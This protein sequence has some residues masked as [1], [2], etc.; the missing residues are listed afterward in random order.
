MD[1]PTAQTLATVRER[2][3]VRWRAVA[4]CVAGLASASWC[5]R[6]DDAMPGAV[7]APARVHQ[8]GGEPVPSAPERRKLVV[9][10][11]GHKE[12]GKASFYGRTFNG[13]KMANGKRFDPNSDAAAS[14]TLPLGT[15]AKVT[16][17]ANG[18][19]ATVTVQDRGPY[20][21]GRIVDVS[22]KTAE[23]LGMKEDGVVPVVVAPIA[24][25]QPDGTVKAGAGATATDAAESLATQAPVAESK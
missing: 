10:R 24:V 25:P 13:R 21:D 17:L 6:A 1:P 14:K 4:A 8:E 5:A 23:K 9:H 7:P 20:V 18:R 15:I 19:S 22:P 12:K 2:T 11:S 3:T 16:N